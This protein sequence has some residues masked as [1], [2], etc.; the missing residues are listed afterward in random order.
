MAAIDAPGRE[1]LVESIQIVAD[2]APHPI[3]GGSRGA[4]TY[5][6]ARPIGPKKSDRHTEVGG[7][8][9]FIYKRHG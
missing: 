5:M 1:P 2:R 7:C 4:A 8:G 9:A 3:P 6:T